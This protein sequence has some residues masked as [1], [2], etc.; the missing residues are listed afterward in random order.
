MTASE[1]ISATR[2]T[3]NEVMFS[4]ADMALPHSPCTLDRL[5]HNAMWPFGRSMTC[6]RDMYG[7]EPL[8]EHMH[9]VGDVL[10]RQV[11]L[12]QSDI[13]DSYL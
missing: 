7:F 12:V 13:S 11:Y 2:K 1:T 3:R 4:V 9:F 8:W 5:S 10:C 6:K